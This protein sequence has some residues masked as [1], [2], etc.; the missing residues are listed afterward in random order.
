M[1]GKFLLW[2]GSRQ[3]Q[4]SILRTQN[5]SEPLIIYETEEVRRQK[6]ARLE[7]QRKPL[8]KLVLCRWKPRKES[9]LAATARRGAAARRT[10]PATSRAASREL[11]LPVLHSFLSSSSSSPPLPLL[12]LFPPQAAGP[13]P[14]SLA[15]MR[16]PRRGGALDGR[17]TGA[18]A[19]HQPADSG[20]S[21]RGWS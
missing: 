6:A 4:P 14:S 2:V 7:R 16:N 10:A 13:S 15:C 8:K 19:P 12:L 5:N 3:R 20:A 1:S 21:R 9:P 17:A 11:L 18:A